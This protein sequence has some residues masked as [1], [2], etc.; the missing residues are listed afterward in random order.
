VLILKNHK[1]IYSG[2]QGY[3]N[4]ELGVAITDKHLFPSDSVTK[5]FTSVLMMQLI[6]N[7]TVE[8]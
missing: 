5:L 8:L 7:G 1:P 6:E 4:F 2:Q 3:A